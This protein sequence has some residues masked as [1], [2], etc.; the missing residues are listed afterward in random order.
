VK[1]HSHLLLVETRLAP[2]AEWPPPKPGWCFAR[3]TEGQGYWLGPGAALEL[4]AGDVFAVAPQ[5]TGAFRA[6]RLGSALLHHFRFCPDSLGGLLTMAERH[7]FEKL[8]ERNHQPW[9]LYRHGHPL[10]VQFGR[11]CQPA[12]ERAGLVARCSLLQWVGTVFARGLKQLRDKRAVVLS[13]Q[14]R[15]QVL[16][17]H[18]TEEDFV[19]VSAADLAAACGCSPRHFSR[20]FLRRFGVSLRKRQTEVRLKRAG[21]LLTETAQPVAAVAAACGYPHLSVFN[22]RFKRR[23]GTTPSLWREQHAAGGAGAED[24]PPG[25]SAVEARGGNP[26]ATAPGFVTE[27]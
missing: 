11:L 27:K 16:M 2:S 15:I 3:L 5:Q 23:F 17:Q 10:S 18:L 19:N 4:N 8:A 25:G 26:G 24:A 7:Y 1:L 6:S 20:L 14:K 22:A 13:A 9:L 21:R 12:P